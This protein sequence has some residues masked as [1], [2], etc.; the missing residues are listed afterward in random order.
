MLTAYLE[1][2]NKYGKGDQALGLRERFTT[3]AE[4]IRNSDQFTEVGK[5]LEIAKRYVDTRKQLDT[6]RE[7]FRAAVEAQRVQLQ[8]GLFGPLDTSPETV[9]SHRAA[10]ALAEQLESKDDAL[11]ELLSRTGSVGGSHHTEG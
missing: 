5:R 2:V 3:D 10:H 4:L 11:K 9:A 8:R 1:R 7:Q 6:L